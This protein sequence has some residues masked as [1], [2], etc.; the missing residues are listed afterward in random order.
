[1]DLHLSEDFG[2]NILNLMDENKN[3]QRRSSTGSIVHNR[4]HDLNFEPSRLN[5]CGPL[6]YLMASFKIHYGEVQGKIIHKAN[7]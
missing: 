4:V 5:A 6:E 1:M 3:G 7:S 2:Q